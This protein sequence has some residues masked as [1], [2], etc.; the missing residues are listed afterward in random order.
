MTNVVKAIQIIYPDIKGGF[1]YWET[2]KDGTKWDDPADGLVW[3]N[4]KYAKPSWSTI[5]TKIAE[6]KL[7]NS[8]NIKCAQI[9]EIR[10]RKV[11]EDSPRYKQAKQ[12]QEEIEKL[13]TVAAVEN[14]DIT[15]I[16][17]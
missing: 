10:N 1:A 16:L 14:Y 5:E 6:V 17:T 2:R 12:A 11:L 8:K 7:Q 9:D 15:K 3:D 4:K 13:T